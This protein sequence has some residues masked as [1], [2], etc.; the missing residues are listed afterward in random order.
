MFNRLSDVPSAML[1]PREDRALE[2]VELKTALEQAA[3]KANLNVTERM[4]LNKKFY[5]N[6][7]GF[8]LFPKDSNFGQY[9]FYYKKGSSDSDEFIKEVQSVKIPEN[10]CRI[11]QSIYKSSKNSYE[12]NLQNA[13]KKLKRVLQ[14]NI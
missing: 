8:S 11:K 7:G 3:D 5:P 10:I 9:T 2:N 14:G 12:Q 4:A 6:G 13:L 1:E